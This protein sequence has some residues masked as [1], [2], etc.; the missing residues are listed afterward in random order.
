MP[1]IPLHP[2]KNPTP[3]QQRAYDTLIGLVGRLGATKRLM[4][5]C[6]ELAEKLQRVGELLSYR[7]TLK[8]RLSELAIPV[9]PRHWDCQYAWYAHEPEAIKGGLSAAVIDSIRAGQRPVF[10]DPDEEAI[11]DY[12]CELHET[13]FVSGQVYQRVLDQLGTCGVVELTA[14]L[15]YYGLVS[16]AINAHEYALP[17]D[18]TPPLPTRT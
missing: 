17:A 3:E 10:D 1:R 8:P 13:H 4:L 12:C 5:H 2:M 6:P 11:Y 16:M 15:G 14:L 9:T 18:V 7:N